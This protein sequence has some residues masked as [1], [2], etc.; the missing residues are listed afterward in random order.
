[1]HVLRQKVLKEGQSIRRVARDLRLSRNTVTK[2]LDQCE[3][4][5]SSRRRE[6]P[7][8]EAVKPRL[9]DLIAEWESRTTAKQRITAMRLHRRL[10]YEGYRA[11]RKLVGDYWR[12]RR[13]QGAEV[14]VPLV[15]RP[16]EAQI[17]SFEAVVEVGSERRKA[18]E[19]L[20]RLM[21]SGREFAWLCERCDQLAWL[22]GQAR[23]F[24]HLGGVAR[25]C[26]YDSLAAAVRKIVAA[27]RE[28]TGRFLALLSH[29]LFEPVFARIGEGHDKGGVESRG[30]AINL[31]Y[32]TPI[33]CGDSLETI[34][35]Q[36]LAELDAVFAARHDASNELG[37]R[38]RTTAARSRHQLRGAQADRST[39]SNSNSPWW[40]VIIPGYAGAL[41]TAVGCT[42]ICCANCSKPRSTIGIK[43]SCAACC[44]RRA[45]PT[46]R[47][48]TNSIGQCSR[49]C[50]DRS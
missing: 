39:A 38:A 4:F 25:R 19:F 2:Y 18:W 7:V 13:R 28:P 10:V 9:A 21:Y 45:F 8:S 40:C 43:A 16:A 1:V 12:E 5:R 22:D 29:Y 26:L 50:H 35:Q 49:E 32:L 30:K 17:D 6:R 46:S 34:S 23:A 11:G 48:S 27:R 31:A 44:A 33:P 42:R 41:A 15:H 3:P 36:L 37:E 24:A 14:Y 20:M 47:P